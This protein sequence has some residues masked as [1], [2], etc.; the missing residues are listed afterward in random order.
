MGR[1]SQ[2]FSRDRDDDATDGL[3]P[4]GSRPVLVHALDGFLGAGSAPR[5]AAEHLKDDDAPV[6]ASFD[7]DDFYDYRA[8]RPPMVFDRDR[9]TSYDAPRLDVRLQHDAAGTPYLLLTGPEPDYRWEQFVGEVHDV[10]DSFDVSLSVGLGAVPMGVPHTRPLMITSHASRPELVDR[11]NLWSGQLV[12]PGSAQALLELR[13]GEWEHDA[14]GYVVHVPQYLAQIDYPTA[15]ISL[16]EALSHRTGLQLDLEPLRLKQADTL[17]DIEKQ[18][19]LQDGGEVLAGL[20]AQYDVFTRGAEDS[21][22][23]DD[24]EIPS[25]DELGQQFERFLARMDRPDDRD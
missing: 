25:A 6:V 17:A 10:V 7:V 11:K 8:R 4:P 16:L 3:L 19:A 13:L 23:A 1:F 21:L 24:E 18:I 9:Y 2:Y 12:V 15:A 5:L 14:V 22:L 20:E